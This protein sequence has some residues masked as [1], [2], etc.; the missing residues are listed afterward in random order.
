MLGNGIKK[1]KDHFQNVQLKNFLLSCPG[2][3]WRY[4]S[5]KKQSMSRL[6][7]GDTVLDDN[8][9]IAK[10]LNIY[11]CSVFTQYNGNTPNISLFE[12]ILLKKYWWCI[13]SEDG[14]LGM[15]LNLDIKKSPGIDEIPNAFLVQ[16]AEWCAA[17]LTL[18]FRK[19]LTRAEL[20]V[21]WRFAKITPIPKADDHSSPSSN[22]P[23]SILC[24]SVKLLEHI[25]F[26]HVSSFA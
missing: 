11:F 25:I 20:P 3:F 4:L 26:K 5:P 24:T 10:T 17:Y 7:I 16:Y 19:S 13:V 9:E 2:K 8:F 14:V 18:L 22:R 1:A 12:E 21:D 6:S 23:I 15:L